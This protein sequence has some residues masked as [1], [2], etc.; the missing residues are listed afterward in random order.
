MAE[1]LNNITLGEN[2]GPKNIS[3]KSTKKLFISTN[4][5]NESKNSTKRSQRENNKEIEESL[6]EVNNLL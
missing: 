4:K 1:K 3:S 6:K 2:F 5:E